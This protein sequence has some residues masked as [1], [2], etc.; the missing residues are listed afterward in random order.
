MKKSVKVAVIGAGPVGIF[1]SLMLQHLGIDHLTIEQFPLL[2]TH[3]SAH[4]ISGRSKQLLSQIPN[5]TQRI[6]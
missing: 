1:S 6:D 5:L 3:P 4:W 2:R